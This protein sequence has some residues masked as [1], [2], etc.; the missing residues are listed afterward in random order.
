MTEDTPTAEEVA[1][2]L[3]A[4]TRR[5]RQASRRELAS[6][7]VTPAQWR[8]LR[9]VERF[10]GPIRMSEL[11]ERL[12]IARRSAT[13]VVNGLEEHGLVRRR[14]DPDDRRS[15]LVTATP[16]GRRLLAELTDHRRR[17]MARQLFVLSPEERRDLHDLLLRLSAGG[18]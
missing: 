17:A 9:A 8:A 18:P 13:D 15:L 16:A 3:D 7:G 6:E 4:T 10:E 1:D 11:A 14:V 12:G 5:I 2:L